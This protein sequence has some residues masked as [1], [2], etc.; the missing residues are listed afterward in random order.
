[1]V[2][3]ADRVRVAAKNGNEPRFVVDSAM[4]RGSLRLPTNIAST[5]GRVTP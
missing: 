2:I 5:T 3:V 1:V 4:Q